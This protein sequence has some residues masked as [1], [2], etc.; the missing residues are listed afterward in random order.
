MA[1]SPRATRS[2]A[3][4]PA[5][6]PAAPI[7][8]DTA[9]ASDAAVPETICMLVGQEGPDLS[10]VRGQVLVIGVDVGA[11]EAQRLVDA[12]FAERG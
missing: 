4:A 5:P 3:P 9:T 10:R 6:A 2:S 7:A 1:K 11:D 8:A 12:E